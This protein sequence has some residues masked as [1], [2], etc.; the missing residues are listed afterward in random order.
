M[1]T[2]RHLSESEQIS[3]AEVGERLIHS[4]RLVVFG[5]NTSC[6]DYIPSLRKDLDELGLT[7]V[8]IKQ[9]RD[10]Y[11]L[12]EGFYGNYQTSEELNPNRTLPAGVILLP[13][14]RQYHEMTGM[15]VPTYESGVPGIVEKMC[16]EN[17]VSL[18]KIYEGYTREKVKSELQK[19]QPHV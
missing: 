15:F 14:M 7:E 1:Q 11:F 13:E 16:Q 8:Q 3:V 18:V 2:E 10:I 17:E 5:S 9:E 12:S 19:L 6:Q 4:N